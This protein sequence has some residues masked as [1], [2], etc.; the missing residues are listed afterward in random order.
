MSYSHYS[1]LYLFVLVLFLEVVVL[2]QVYYV[3]FNIFY[4]HIV[5]VDCGVV[6]NHQLIVYAMLIFRPICLLSSD[7]S[8][9]ICCKSCGVHVHT[10][11]SLAKRRLLRNFPSIFT[12]LFFQFNLLN[13]LH[14]VT[15]KSLDEMVSPYITPLL[16]LSFV[17]NYVLLL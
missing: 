2:L 15:T 5:H 10:N 12:P 9:C 4:H 16:I 11:M 8:C 7:S 13:L 14:R 6:Y 17:H 1:S 3:T